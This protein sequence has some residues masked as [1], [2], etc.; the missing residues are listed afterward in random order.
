MFEARGLENNRQRE[1]ESRNVRGSVEERNRQRQ[2]MLRARKQ[3]EDEYI[4][5]ETLES[6]ERQKIFGA[7]VREKARA[8]QKHRATDEDEW[9]KER[10]SVRVAKKST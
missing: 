10:E 9:Y 3:G 4:H 5:T 1:R 6:E 8:T 7:G 2:R